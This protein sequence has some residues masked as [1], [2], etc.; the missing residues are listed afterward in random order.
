MLKSL[1]IRNIVLIDSLDVD[2]SDGL[3]ILSGETG[4]GKS[5][6]LDSLNLLLG[7]RS[8]SSLVRQGTD[9]LSVTGV[10]EVTKENKI[11]EIAKQY[12]LDIDD[13]IIIKRIITADGKN[14]ILFNDQIIT[15][16][17]LKELAENLVEIHGQHDSQGLLNPST[18]CEILDNYGRYNKEQQTVANLFEAYKKALRELEQ[19]KAML[20]KAKQ[21]EENLKHWLDE[22]Q[23]TAPEKGEEEKLRNRRSELM[24]A[25]KILDKLNTAYTCLNGRDSVVDN[26]SKAYNAI[27]KANEIVNNKYADIE[28]NLENTLYTLNDIIEQIQTKSSDISLSQNEIDNIET[29]LFLLKDLAKK[30]QTEIDLLPEKMQEIR[31]ALE[32]L[33]NG[34]EG[35]KDLEQKV[36]NL[37][38]EYIKA[39]ETLS[40]CRKKAAKELDKNIMQELTPLKMEKA[41]F[42]TTIKEKPENLWTSNGWDNVNFEISTNPNTPLGPLNKIAS[43]GELSRLMLALKVHLAGKNS[44]ETLVFDEIDAGIGGATAEAV[45]ERLS[46]LAQ[47]EQVFVVTHLPQVAAFGNEN[48]KVSKHT[49]D[50]VTTTTLNKLTKKEKLE[51]IAR[52]LAGEKITEEARAAAQALLNKEPKST[53][54]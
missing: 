38:K 37:R 25:E 17:L 44:Q 4:A 9:K 32:S 51:E 30:H 6:L 41:V 47:K 29:R 21:D 16:K 18:H 53:L 43:G 5:M 12:D 49:K 2:F 33:Q 36:E 45:G 31:E 14:K 1:S 26:V 8:D 28:Q 23:K 54:F 11:Y 52:M 50:N 7:E 35:I 10:F 27:S 42:Q 34:E 46:R 3:V 39:S 13:D 20:S 40:A 15:L 19:K 48:L 24:N 22:L